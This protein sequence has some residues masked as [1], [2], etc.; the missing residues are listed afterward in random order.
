LIVVAPVFVTVAAARTAN[1]A[2]LCSETGAVAALAATAPV[3]PS[4]RVIASASVAARASRERAV[5]RR[6]FS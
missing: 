6:V 3:V 4:R 5:V 1:L 2:A